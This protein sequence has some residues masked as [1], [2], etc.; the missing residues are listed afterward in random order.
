M[1]AEVR[2]QNAAVGKIEWTP[3]AYGAAVKLDC[4]MPCE[5]L[6]LLRCYGETDG[7]PLL[8]GLPEPQ[9]GRLVLAR[10]LSRETLKEAG[11]LN[12]APHSFF[13]SDGRP[14]KA[15]KTQ[16][17]PLDK[18]QK[19]AEGIRTGDTVLDGL[20]EESGIS[21]IKAGEETLELCCP[22]APDKPFLLAPAFV[23]CTVQENKALL[24]WRKK[25]AAGTAAS[26][27]TII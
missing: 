17:L 24:R 16:V 2:F 4:D 25:D 9:N 13:L 5:P 19:T 21:V 15:E 10:R 6:R 18:R 20:L 22:F 7:A 1:Q 8:I 26:K 11:C 27:K 14:E 3:D 12:A 23:L